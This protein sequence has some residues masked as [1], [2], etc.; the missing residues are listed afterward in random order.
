MKLHELKARQRA[1]IRAIG[2]G[3]EQMDV[4]LREVGFSEGD[5]VE[6]V[7]A[8][9]FGGRTLAVRLNRTLIAL[10]TSEAALVEVDPA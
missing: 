7:G 9:P 5:E 4:K 2:A 1:R 10:R 6:M 3:S 8:G